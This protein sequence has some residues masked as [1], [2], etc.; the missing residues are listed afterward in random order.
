MPKRTVSCPDGRQRGSLLEL[1]REPA[2]RRMILRVGDMQL[3]ILREMQ[4]NGFRVASKISQAMAFCCSVAVIAGNAEA[5]SFSC[6]Y[7]KEAACLDY[8][9]KVCSSFAKCV[10]QDA[11]CFAS[12]QCNYEGFTCKSNLT[13]LGK[14]YDELVNDYNKLVRDFRSLSD[15]YDDLLNKSRE[16]AHAHDDLRSRVDDLQTC[17]RH[18]DTIYEAQDCSQ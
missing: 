11:V 18:A 14:K 13:D 2:D 1:R 6:P 7:G 15:D 16:L 12:Y 3:T 8:F 4:G 5:Q 17:I 9:D 10:A